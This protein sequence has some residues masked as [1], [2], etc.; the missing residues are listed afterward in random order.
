VKL[1]GRAAI[2][3]GAGAG[4]G[5]AIA[6]LFAREGAR[7]TCADLD[8]DAADRV[9]AEIRAEGGEALAIGMDHTLAAD[10][11]RTVAA[12]TDAFESLDVLV[13]NAGV[14]IFGTAL[15]VSEEDFLRQLRVNLLG[16][17][18]M[19]RSALPRMIE[20]RRGSIVM[21]A[22][23][24]G[25]LARQAGA[26]YVSSKHGL[27]GLTKSL[28][29]DY[30]GHGIRVNAVC[31]GTIRTRMSQSYFEELARRRGTNVEE[32][33]AG[34]GPQYALGRIGEPEDV[35]QATLHFASDESGWVTGESYLLD[36]GQSLLGPRP[37]LPPSEQP[38]GST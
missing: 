23:A 7:V 30:G 11:E 13:N 32:V 27:V 38:S 2:V 1:E 16:P 28:A 19:T 29:V 36:G 17:F 5:E 12:T 35:A 3:T 34:L 6:R 22:S 9:A 26:A 18:L 14:V 21:M 24:A 4:N 33:V 31:P 20:Q 10:C 37:P 15:E 8:A 25:L